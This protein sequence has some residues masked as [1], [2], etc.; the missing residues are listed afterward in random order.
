VSVSRE[1]PEVVDA[2]VRPRVSLPRQAALMLLRPIGPDPGR[3]ADGKL[4][5]WALVCLDVVLGGTCV[6]WPT[7]YTRI[8]HPLLA[9]PQIDL[10]QRTGVLW[11]MYATIAA[12]AATR[13][14]T[15]RGRWFFVLGVVRLIEVPTDVVY[16]FIAGGAVWYSRLLLFGAPVVNLAA[17]LF[18]VALARELAQGRTSWIRR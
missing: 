4:L 6:A 16:G 9:E 13:G 8:I 15:Q 17:G 10:V 14:E 12:F 5:A 2:P 7:L 1:Q 3:I 18:L 11:L